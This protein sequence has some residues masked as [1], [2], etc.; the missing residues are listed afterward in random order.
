MLNVQKAKKKS[1]C[2]SEP[3]RTGRGSCFST[4]IQREAELGFRTA[5]MLPP[6]LL[7]EEPLWNAVW[8]PT[9][10]RFYSRSRTT[11]WRS[12]VSRGT[13]WGSYREIIY[14]CTVY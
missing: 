13:V 3:E 1:E 5:A 9:S 10:E 14:L 7:T 6:L 11:D 8:K 4:L 2:E 12:T